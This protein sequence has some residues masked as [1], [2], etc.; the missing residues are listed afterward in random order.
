MA[1]SKHPA[2][3]ARHP[4]SRKGRGFVID[5]CGSAAVH[6]SAVS[7]MTRAAAAKSIF[8]AV[9]PLGLR[10]AG[11]V[12]TASNL[13]GESLVRLCSFGKLMHVILPARDSDRSRH[14]SAGT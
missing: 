7:G 10:R 5:V 12:P 14:G 11:K 6:V 8:V 9:S 4:G 13:D 1:M 2:T 3:I